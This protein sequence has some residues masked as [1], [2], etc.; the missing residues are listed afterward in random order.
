MQIRPLAL[1]PEATT[2]LVACPWSHMRRRNP[3]NKKLIRE[4]L[5]LHWSHSRKSLKKKNP[6]KWRS[7][8]CLMMMMR[9]TSFKRMSRSLPWDGLQRPS[10]SRSV[11][12]RLA[13]ST[14]G[15][16]LDLLR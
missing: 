5:H 1:A 10:T 16:S 4:H 8:Y 7:S 6:K 11:K 14:H 3:R 2:R 13:P 12:P 9:K 15:D